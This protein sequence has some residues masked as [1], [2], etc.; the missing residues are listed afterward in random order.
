MALADVAI[1]EANASLPKGEAP[2]DAVDHFARA[3]GGRPQRVVSEKVAFRWV[4]EADGKVASDDVAARIT[5]KPHD[6]TRGVL[7]S[8]TT[9][10]A[11]ADP[12]RLIQ[13]ASETHHKIDYFAL[14]RFRMI[15]IE[16]AVPARAPTSLAQTLSLPGLG[17][18][19]PPIW[20][21]VE[22]WSA[23]G[24]DVLRRL[25]EL[26]AR[27]VAPEKVK[28]TRRVEFHPIGDDEPAGGDPV[29][30]AEAAA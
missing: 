9:F 15:E 2:L 19:D 29:A 1:G 4:R 23:E 27:V 22:F 20:E 6:P 8:T 11:P 18:N 12:G 25:D 7:R 28:P 26:A 5:P 3:S 16:D 30:S 13:A 21:E 17:P 24:A 10:A 14:R